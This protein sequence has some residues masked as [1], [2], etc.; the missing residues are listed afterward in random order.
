MKEAIALIPVDEG[1]AAER[2]QLLVD[3]ETFKKEIHD[4]RRSIAGH[5]NHPDA[6]AKSGLCTTLMLGRVTRSSPML[7]V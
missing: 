2:A 3:I 6:D 1:K 4:V 5:F 7:F